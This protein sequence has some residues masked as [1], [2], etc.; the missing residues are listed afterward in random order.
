[1]IAMTTIYN[2][3]QIDAARLLTLR[4]MLRLEM[5]GMTKKGR[6][7]Y[8]ILKSEFGFRGSREAVFA[9]LTEWRNQVINKA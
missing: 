4:Q 2:P 3:D 1:M 6:S 8:S 5:L 7:A 9:A